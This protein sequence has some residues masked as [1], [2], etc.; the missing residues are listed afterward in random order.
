MKQFKLKK[1]QQNYN[2]EP[3]LFNTSDLPNVRPEDILKI[4]NCD[5]NSSNFM[6]FKVKTL[7]DCLPKDTVSIETTLANAFG[8]HVFQNVY[9]EQVEH[10]EVTI[11]LFEVTFKDQYISRSDMWR[12]KKHLVNSCAHI[13][14]YLEF[15]D[16]RAQVSELW[17]NSTK[18][19]FGY[20]SDNTNFVL[21]SFTAEVYV[22]IQM[23]SEMWEF[24][25]YGYLQFER[26]VNGFL[27][28]LFTQW[29][30]K[31]CCHELTLV[32][33]S[34]TFYETQS[35][36]DFPENIRDAI[37]QDYR[38]VFYTD[39]YKCVVQ[40]QRIDDCTLLLPQLKELFHGYEKL[41]KIP[42]CP[43]GRNSSSAEGNFLEAIN[44]SLNVFE[45]HNI[46]RNFDR[47]G[48]IVVCVT[49]GVGVFDVDRDLTILTKQRMIDNGIGSDLICLGQQPLHAVPLFKFH[50]RHIGCN[51]TKQET[52][53][54]RNSAKYDNVCGHDFNIPHWINH[55]FYTSN[56]FPDKGTTNINY[57]PRV[58]VPINKS[59]PVQSLTSLPASKSHSAGADELPLVQQMS[60]AEY[61]KQVFSYQKPG[62]SVKA[63]VSGKI[64]YPKYFAP[65]SSS[66][67]QGQISSP[68]NT[69]KEYEKRGIT[70]PVYIPLSKMHK[71]CNKLENGVA[72]SLGAVVNLKG[73]NQES[74]DLRPII[75]SAT[76]S[77]TCHGYRKNDTVTQRRSL[78]NP[79]NP[80]YMFAP[81]TANRR[82]WV[83]TYPRGP[84]GEA[85]VLHHENANA[86]HREASLISDTYANENGEKSQPLSLAGCDNSFFAGS[87]TISPYD[88][89]HH[90]F[91]S[92]EYKD[93]ATSN[94]SVS[95]GTSR[96][97]LLANITLEYSPA[98][99]FAAFKGFR[100]RKPISSYGLSWIWGIAGDIQWTSDT[101]TGLD[102]K[103][104][105]CP[106]C[107]PITTDYCPNQHHLQNA[108]TEQAYNLVPD[109]ITSHNDKSM[110]DDTAKAKQN[111]ND[112]G[113]RN[114]KEIFLEL[115]N[116][117]LCQGFQIIKKTYRCRNTDSYSSC[118]TLTSPA[119]SELSFHCMGSDTSPAYIS[120]AKGTIGEASV[121]SYMLSHGRQY[122]IVSLLDEEDKIGVKI[123]KPRH[124]FKTVRVKYN[125]ML[126]PKTRSQFGV[127]HTFFDYEKVEDWYWNHLDNYVCDPDENGPELDMNLKWWQTKFVLITSPNR[128]LQ[129]LK[130]ANENSADK[131]RFDVFSGCNCSK[132]HDNPLEAGHCA[133]MTEGFIRFLEH[134][135]KFKRANNQSS[136]KS[137]KTLTSLSGTLSKSYSSITTGGIYSSVRA[138]PTPPPFPSSSTPTSSECSTPVR[139][140]LSD[141]AHADK[142]PLIS[143]MLMHGVDAKPIPIKSTTDNILQ[144][145]PSCEKHGFPSLSTKS[146]LAEIAAALK[147]QQYGLNF[148]PAGCGVP[149]Y[150]FI[151]L[152]AVHWSLE[153]ID[154]IIT[155]K[156]ACHLFETMRKLNFFSHVSGNSSCAF[157]YGYILYTMP[158]D[159]VEL[160]IED[161][162]SYQY[163]SM[164]VGPY[165]K[166]QNR[167]FEV[168]INYCN[169]DDVEKDLSK[170]ASNKILSS[171]NETVDS[172][173]KQNLCNKKHIQ[174]S[175]NHQHKVVTIP[176][177]NKMRAHRCE[178][179]QIK[180]SSSTHVGI[181]TL[182]F[183]FELL[184][185]VAT[186]TSI[187]NM[188]QVMFREAAR[189]D[190]Y[191]FPVPIN[192]FAFPHSAS[193]SP[194]TSPLF[195]SL[196]V[197][198]IKES[199]KESSCTQS[200][201]HFIAT[202]MEGIL[203]RFGF[204]CDN[205]DASNLESAVFIHF[206]GQVLTQ[207]CSN[208]DTAQSN[209]S[210]TCS[211]ESSHFTQRCQEK[212][213]TGFY[214]T[215]N[216]MQT[217]RW[218]LSSFTDECVP[219]ELEEDFVKFC[220]NTD[221]R[222]ADFAKSLC[223][224]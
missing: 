13:D 83:H 166:T 219:G 56:P 4:Y 14:Q 108:Y 93:Y 215:N 218:K 135:N 187:F 220:S 97:S 168:A 18:V 195:I 217:K 153:N 85:L 150:S 206:T 73:Y 141:T 125:Y 171:A 181:H 44:M 65:D 91:M 176:L 146:D 75:G 154:D 19:K 48:Q 164:L 43:N 161:P 179:C 72:S 50:H 29:K 222:L 117:R 45:K 151:S 204:V 96:R 90:M 57:I 51:S 123:Y 197:Q 183:S 211:V 223:S 169:N 210:S 23:S 132:S 87:P 84:Q 157:K 142:P 58:H 30:N 140:L 8:L 52:E 191:L 12:L 113:S 128:R 172:Q 126:W 165:S 7:S 94:S 105:K 178:W 69:V 149:K 76:N 201:Q 110:A 66:S 2:D 95:S 162:T 190:L 86:F 21:R 100:S 3:L 104:L 49:P 71:S 64:V 199:I 133:A 68:R 5:G 101:N 189:C 145:V 53:S 200:F 6:L 24:D 109:E 115:I 25:A 212:E 167:W 159:N 99:G 188:L 202:L 194:L 59:K 170:N 92:K 192:P 103:S 174:F 33:F 61:D 136:R 47:T 79:F 193:L 175:S 138:T 102:W 137:W 40:M 134:L 152:E 182:V 114:S 208:S 38:N 10:E 11:D 35:I 127:E 116:Q 213:K 70:K 62:T 82:R 158:E 203:H 17:T 198:A 63:Q 155:I 74:L 1:H 196:N 120:S 186:A 111:Y 81:L 15:S 122:H 42:G 22:F 118:V 214:W 41:T 36:E 37:R 20:I 28:A 185:I 32:L 112:R 148:L 180:Y 54:P 209:K 147:H 106:A 16:I 131:S 139:S 9:V 205:T 173:E 124:P 107:L 98:E 144:A 163:Q 77:R 119:A 221:L 31:K 27:K 89:Q 34:R 121:N 55:S 216:Y 88:E 184:W 160:E 67:V 130:T 143:G 207:I 26:A 156:D 177:L 60:Y 224:G 78:F 39:F 46:D 80:S 129:V